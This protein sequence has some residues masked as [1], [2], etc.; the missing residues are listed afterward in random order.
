MDSKLFGSCSHSCL[1]KGMCVDCGHSLVSVEKTKDYIN[2]EWLIGNSSIIVSKDYAT[3]IMFQKDQQNSF[4]KK[5]L[6]LVLDLDETLI[7]SFKRKF[8][9]Q[10]QKQIENENDLMEID[11]ECSQIIDGFQDSS[12][13]IGSF[14][15]SVVFRPGL[16][17]F[18]NEISVYFDIY[19]YTHGTAI[20]SENIMKLLKKR[21][22][23]KRF[24][25]NI[26]GLLSRQNSKTKPQK[27][28]KK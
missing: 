24:Q 13:I 20:Y 11:E 12:F 28:L 15:Y 7:H 26:Q 27:S 18:L 9:Q 17:E 2:L 25:F 10:I 4:E 5:K 3:N 16:E 8:Q 1:F 23:M 6:K 14:I 21:I 22:E 19:V